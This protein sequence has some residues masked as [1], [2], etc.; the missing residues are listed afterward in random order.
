VAKTSENPDWSPRSPGARLFMAAF[1]IVAGT[2]LFL[3]NLGVLPIQSIWSFWPLLIAGFGISKMV[4]TPD[5]THRLLG[6]LLTVFGVLFTLINIG[7]IHIRARDHSWPISMLLIAFGLAMLIKVLDRRD[8]GRPMWSSFRREPP[9]DAANL[10]SDLAVMGS[11]KRRLDAADFRGGSALTI[12]G[13][14]ELDLRHSRITDP[15][16]TIY[17]EV[18]AILGSAKIRVPENWRVRIHGAGIM[19]N[20]EDKTVPAAAC[21]E[22]PTLFVSGY[23][24]MAEVEI[25]D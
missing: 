8:P 13:S 7:V 20:Y 17:L 4:N 21:A 23:A 10:L 16:Q 1:L 6:A 25:E 22:G 9:G 5:R 24:L 3:G 14:I 12:L 19:G 2:L 11:V 18:S 15:G